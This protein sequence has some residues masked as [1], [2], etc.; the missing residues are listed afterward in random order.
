MLLFFR[1]GSNDP[2]SPKTP[3]GVHRE[4]QGR[5]A[6]P[7]LRV[8][9]IPNPKGVASREP[10]RTSQTGVVSRRAA[11]VIEKVRVRAGRTVR[12]GIDD[13][14]PLGL[15]LAWDSYP[16]CAARPWALGWNALRGARARGTSVN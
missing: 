14:T 16:R 10:G 8:A 6:H 4:A 9:V 13:A 5:A 3:T 1:M 11:A 12:V 2:G 7:G 15:A